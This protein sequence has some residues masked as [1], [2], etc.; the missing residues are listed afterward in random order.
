MTE[1][2]F[3]MGFGFSSRFRRSKLSPS[4][5]NCPREISPRQ[6]LEAAKPGPGER[7]AQA[8]ASPKFLF[9]RRG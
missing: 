1:M 7:R 4:C 8:E 5:A 6:E 9:R 3:K 2:S